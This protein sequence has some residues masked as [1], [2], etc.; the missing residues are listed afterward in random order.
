MC[1]SPKVSMPKTDTK[2]LAVD[3]APLTET[4][5]SVAFGGQDETQAADDSGRKSL[6][7]KKD[8]P[9]GAAKKAFGR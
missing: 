7:V 5:T 4:P 8:A 1:F 6:T 3:P 2:P 9:K